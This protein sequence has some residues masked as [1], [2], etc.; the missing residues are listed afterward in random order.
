M[1]SFYSFVVNAIEEYEDMKSFETIS[2]ISESLS[3]LQ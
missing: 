1:S 3:F 2:I